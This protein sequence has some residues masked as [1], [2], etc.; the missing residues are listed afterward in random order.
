[1]E[2]KSNFVIK[3]KYL[4]LILPIISFSQTFKGQI[5]DMNGNSISNATVQIKSLN[6]E[7]T[8]LFTSTNGK[9]KFEIKKNINQQNALL[10]ISFIGYKTLKKEFTINADS[11]DF[12]NIVLLEN[13]E[14]LKEVIVKA[15]S[16]GISQKGYTTTFKIERFL[17]GTEENLKDVIQRIPG[18]NIN[19]KGKITANGKTIDKLLI[20]GED[21]YKNQHQIATENLPSNL[22]NSIE[23]IQNYIGHENLNKE[24]K[25]G[26]TALN[27]KI[28]EEYKN[29]INGFIEAGK[30]FDSQYKVKNSIFNFNKKI[31][32]SVITNLNNIAENPISIDDYLDLTEE[33]EEGTESKVIFSNLNEIPNFLTSKD[34]VSSKKN[35]FNSINLIYNINKKTKLDFYSII[36]NANQTLNLFREQKY[37]DLDTDLTIIEDKKNTEK[38]TFG[39][40]NAK[41]VYKK[42]ENTIHIIKTSFLFDISKNSNNIINFTNSISKEIDQGNQLENQTF[43]LSYNLSKK[44][45]NSYFN[46]K[47]FYINSTNNND[48]EIKSN[49]VFL[50]TN[51]LN[52]DNSLI[53]YSKKST[54]EFKNIGSYQFRKNKF[55]FQF[56]Q[57]LSFNNFQLNSVLNNSENINN[58]K[59]NNFLNSSSLSIKYQINSILDISFKPDYSLNTINFNN[60]SQFVSYFGYGASIKAR[61]NSTNILQI[62]NSLSNNNTNID[63]LLVS[64]IVKDYRTVTNNYNAASTS[65]L[66]SLQYNLN[67]FS[68]DIKN[69]FSFIFNASHRRNIKSIENNIISTENITF[70]SNSII[71]EEKFNSMLVFIEKQ[72]RKLPFAFS[73]STSYTNL[74]KVVLNNN[75]KI[76]FKNHLF[77]GM[78]EIKS[79]YKEFPVYFNVGLKTSNDTY[80]YNNFKSNLDTYQIYCKLNGKVFKNIYWNLNT[81]YFNFRNQ[82]IKTNY[83]NISPILRFSKEK[84]NFEYSLIGNNVLNINSTNVLENYSNSNYSELVRKPVLSGYILLQ[85]KYKF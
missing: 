84:T 2:S 68:F 63:N 31:Q 1:M 38:N 82:S 49:N 30:G 7:N 51:Y 59:L 27:I 37:Y 61:F 76:D 66:P 72:P 12:G 45:K 9:G 39:T 22:I 60:N 28:K 67:Y 58:L 5:L 36:N 56:F 81:D 24:E 33:K 77:S 83:L 69:K 79:K 75:N 6:E 73:I 64:D 20:D 70:L 62:S 29:K 18:L 85:L 11:I 15:E 34:R 19:D 42:N 71:S 65:I 53:Q 44:I 50:I 47:S 52:S 4:L 26:K 78:F 40:I 8:L 17:N 14:E 23:L 57:T 74:S 48:L 25:S 55:T 10:K 21:L 16:S 35:T 41:L 46:F 32:F 3:I 54:S 43:N 80:F 13:I